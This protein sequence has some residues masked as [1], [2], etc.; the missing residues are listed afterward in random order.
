MNFVYN[1]LAYGDALDDICHKSDDIAFTYRLDSFGKGVVFNLT[2]LCSGVFHYNVAYNIF[3][4]VNTCDAER[5]G[6][7]AVCNY[8]I[9]CRGC[10]IVA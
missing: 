4:I 3:N 9:A 1:F 8:G 5:M 10:R 7:Y 2:Y 6:G